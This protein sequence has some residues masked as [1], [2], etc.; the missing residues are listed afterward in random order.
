MAVALEEAARVV[1]PDG[2]VTVVFGHGD[3]DVWRRLLDAITSGGL[4][5]T[6][7]WPARTEKGGQAGSSNIQT[8]L[9][10]CC[11]PIGQ[12]RPLGRVNEVRA[13]IRRVI[14][15]RVPLW[16]MSGL[17][18][19]DQLMASAGPAMEV[20][21]RY[22]E[23]AD[24]AGEKVDSY[25]FLI[26]A[27]RAVQEAAAIRIDDLPLETFDARTQFGLFWSRLFGRGVAAKSE[28]RW[29]ALASS[30]TMDDLR[31]VLANV[32]KAPGSASGERPSGPLPRT[33]TSS[34][35]LSPY[36][37]PGRKASTRS[38][39]SSRRSQR[40][41][42]DI[43]DD[44]LFAALTYSDPA[45]MPESDPDRRRTASPGTEQQKTSSQR[46][47]RLSRTRRANDSFRAAR[48][49][50]QMKPAVTPWWETIRLRAE[51]S[52]A[53]G[54][55]IDDVQMSLFNAVYGAAGEKPRYAKPG[56][57]GEI[58]FPSDNL[59]DLMAESRGAARRRRRPYPAPAL[60]TTR[61]GHGRRQIPRPRRPVA[62]RGPPAGPSSDRHR[63][64]SAH[65]RL[66]HRRRSA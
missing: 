35:W 43:N 27:R 18:L 64:G 15:E 22:C 39:T 33:P 28:A 49:G 44:H 31:G 48:R 4:Y 20:V 21:G 41:A 5:L 32:E 13:E 59:V 66:T 10:M 1:R 45:R 2:V 30:L 57:Y 55:L 26:L 58:T 19:T 54:G 23:V 25:D 6:G 56:Y 11:R 37:A 34:M 7:S 50:L 61:P 29:Q 42:R 17:A 40:A 16:E 38:A 9:T 62:P 52:E 53:S 47:A 36:P 3:P 65:R 51:I 63:Q 24:P 14:K 8:T 46:L 12:G 60:Y